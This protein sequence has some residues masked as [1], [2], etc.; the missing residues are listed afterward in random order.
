MRLAADLTCLSGGGVEVVFTVRNVGARPLTIENDFHLTLSVVRGRGLVFG[1]VVFVFPAPG[2]QVI[3]PGESRTF[4]V[5][6]GDAVGG[7]GGTD[8]SGRGLILE[9]EVWFVG[10]D[11]V[12]R[13]NFWFPACNG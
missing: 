1:G 7:E 11:G 2:F 8:L 6:I 5:P 12:V 10:R 9:A 3:P 13:R 4:R